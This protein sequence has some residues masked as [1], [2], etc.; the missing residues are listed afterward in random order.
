MKPMASLFILTTKADK[1]CVLKQ[2]SE[3]ISS[4]ALWH[5][6][7]QVLAL[8]SHSAM[9]DILFTEGIPSTSAPCH[10]STLALE[11]M[12]TMSLRSLGHGSLN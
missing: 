11:G 1:L 4:A 2:C 9:S 8:L 5:R 10:Q 3:I 6:Q 7:D 12:N